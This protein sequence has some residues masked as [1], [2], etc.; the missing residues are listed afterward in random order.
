[1]HITKDI[2][3]EGP[4]IL[5]AD[6]WSAIGLSVYDCTNQSTLYDN[7]SLFCIDVIFSIYFCTPAVKLYFYNVSCTFH[8]YM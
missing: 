6:H 4:A 1:V 2:N 8:M 7:A 3:F 5:V